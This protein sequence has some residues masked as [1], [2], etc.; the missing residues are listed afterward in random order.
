MSRYE[1]RLK[2]ADTAVDRVFAETER[3]VLM[4]GTERRAI[5]AVLEKPDGESHLSGGGKIEHLS[6]ALSVYTS[7][8]T[9][10]LTRHEVLI[11]SD[12][13]WVSHIGADEMGR[14]RLTL[15]VGIPNQSV[16]DITQWSA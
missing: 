9:G 3:I 14:T 13:Y 16:A 2:R 5:T 12:H 7:D 4:I 15:A 1:Q 6:P 11:G 10:L 8:I